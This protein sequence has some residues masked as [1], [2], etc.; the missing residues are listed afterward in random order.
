MSRKD[1]RTVRKQSGAA[2]VGLA[3]S[4][5]TGAA[6]PDGDDTPKDINDWPVTLVNYLDRGCI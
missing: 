3:G 6:D 2:I 4:S 5:Q 1:R